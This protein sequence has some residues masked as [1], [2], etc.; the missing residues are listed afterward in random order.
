VLVGQLGAGLDDGPA[1]PGRLDLP[2]LVHLPLHRKGQPI[3]AWVQGTQV[4][5]ENP[6]KPSLINTGLAILL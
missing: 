6:V 1:E 4:F 5:A 2:G 3:D